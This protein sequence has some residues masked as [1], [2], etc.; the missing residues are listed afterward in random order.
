MILPHG[1][2]DLVHLVVSFSRSPRRAV[3]WVLTS[4]TVLFPMEQAASIRLSV[5]DCEEWMRC[6]LT[7]RQVVFKGPAR[8]ARVQEQRS[9]VAASGCGVALESTA[10]QA[11]STT[12]GLYADMI[13][14]LEQLAQLHRLQEG[15]TIGR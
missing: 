4:R 10:R 11:A 9:H 5:Y 7:E 2:L 6:T 14:T 12:A 1:G 15:K 13:G 3:S 8:A